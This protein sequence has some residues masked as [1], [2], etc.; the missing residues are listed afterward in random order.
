MSIGTSTVGIGTT[1]PSTALE[2]IGTVTATGFSGNGAG[3]TNLA[4]FNGGN[5]TGTLTTTGG[6]GIGVGTTTP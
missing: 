3:L 2:V 1:T 4:S 5:I 6:A